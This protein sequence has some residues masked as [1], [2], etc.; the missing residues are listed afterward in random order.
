MI[1]RIS[2]ASIVDSAQV[3]PVVVLMGPRQSG[4]TTLAK[5]AFPSYHYVTL[6][7][8]DTQQFAEEDPRG[9][10]Q[11]YSAQVIIDEAQLA[12]SLFSY[13]QELVDDDPSPG[14]FIL[15]GSQNFL[16]MESV[17]QSL[18][19]RVALHK[20]L[21]LSLQ[22]LSDAQL[23][24]PSVE[25]NIWQGGY[26]RIYN[27]NL[28]P[29]QWYSDY[30]T[31]Y[32]ERDVRT[33]KHITQLA[34]FQRFL[35]LCAARTGQ[36]LNMTGIANDCGISVNTAKSWLSILE[37]SFI[38]YLLKP[39]YRNFNKRMIKA[40]KLYFY[41]TGLVCSLLN[42]QTVDQLSVHHSRGEL[43]ENFIINEVVK[44][45]YNHNIPENL[46][47]WRDKT[48][49]EIDLL[50]EKGDSLFNIEIKSSKTIQ[51]TYFKNLNW[52]SGV[53]D[54]NHKNWLVYGGDLD[55]KREKVSVLSWLN[56]S[57]LFSA[58]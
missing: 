13:L 39:Y 18:S 41:D 1:P 8:R 29:T 21:P 37:A 15:T 32:I 33:L 6:S 16:L 56:L 52:F 42:I 22:E 27:Q 49:H 19:G 26:P 35:K 23:L 20:L 30:I 36:I 46:Y 58:F 51:T 9:F 14:R 53:M 54:V 31:T 2:L 24:K 50:V 44:Y 38:I 45:E 48:G 5:A 12:P 17:S 40:P 11:Q 55:Q 28:K 57:E 10:L 25:R 43:F 4:K 34:E 7:N 47:Y 3:S